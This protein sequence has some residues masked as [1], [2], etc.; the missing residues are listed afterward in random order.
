MGLLLRQRLSNNYP[1]VLGF[2]ATEIS[3]GGYSLAYVAYASLI[4]GPS[5]LSAY[6][7]SLSFLITT[8]C[9]IIFPTS[10]FA[11]KNSV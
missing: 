10:L 9:S 7:S 11:T 1:G 3:L 8:L 4:T 6:A 2:L 5:K